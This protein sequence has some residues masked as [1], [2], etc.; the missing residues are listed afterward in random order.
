[1]TAIAQ[2]PDTSDWLTPRLH[3]RLLWAVLGFTFASFGLSYGA[4]RLE[5]FVDVNVAYHIAGVSMLLQV[6]LWIAVCTY[7]AWN[8]MS[9]RRRNIVWAGGLSGSFLLGTIGVLSCIIP[10]T[11]IV[12]TQ[13]WLAGHTVVEIHGD[14]IRVAGAISHDLDER[15]RDVATGEI[16]R[17]EL[18]K[19]S[20]GMVGG[21]LKAEPLLRK[22]GV[23]TV[24]ISGRCASSC[25]LLALMFPKRFITPGGQLGFH[26]LRPAAGRD[27]ASVIADTARVSARLESLG[28]APDLVE[29]L[30]STVDLHWYAPAEARSRG[31]VTGCWD[32]DEVM[33]VPCS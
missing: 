5:Q 30:F 4:L 21:V 2:P 14:V 27:D 3:R 6:L 26:K 11:R 29:S 8:S 10:V 24:V 17:L 22:L 31:L 23:D 33:E 12:Q 15:I 19:N 16:H 7:A 32:P 1:M 13:I 25:A 9:L 28:Y 20:G 18:A